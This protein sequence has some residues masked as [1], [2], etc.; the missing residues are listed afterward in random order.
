[1]AFD[2]CEE[3]AKVEDEEA[4]IQETDASHENPETEAGKELRAAGFRRDF[5]HYGRMLKRIKL[6]EA[7]IRG[8]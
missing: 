6:H 1:M 2:Q 7:A 5:L 3:A 4:Q 8:D